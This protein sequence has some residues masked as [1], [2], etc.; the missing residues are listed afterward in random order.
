MAEKIGIFLFFS[1]Y[2]F[3]LFSGNT[4][5]DKEMWELVQKSNLGLS[6]IS[7]VPQILTNFQNKSTGQLSFFTFLLSFLGV[8]ARLGT[9]LFE[10]DNF[11]YQL[12]YILS[13]ALNGMIVLQFILYWN[14]SGDNA[15][16]K[17]AS[18]GK[19]ASGKPASGKP[20]SG[21]ATATKGKR[22]KLE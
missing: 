16:G 10:T 9:V 15:K 2:S 13:A 18:T 17:P 22:D 14:N 21:K 19:P 3:V 11:L 4:Y 20:A 8:L 1:S 6:L 5:F 7:R 12:Q